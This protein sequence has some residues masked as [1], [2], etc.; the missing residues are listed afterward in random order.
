MIDT[1][2]HLLEVVAETGDKKIADEAV[3]KL[4]KH[5]KSTGRS[6]MLREIATELRKIAARRHALA[7]KVEVASH[8][9]EAKALKEA[10]AFG[11]VAK[12]AVVNKSLISGW[13]AQKAGMLVDRS[14]KRALVDIYKN[15][16]N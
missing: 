8:K 9:E 3:T 5:L 14:G 1:Y 12:Q 16:T 11:I 10:K 13:R 6:K 4:I 7:P 15:V 2:T